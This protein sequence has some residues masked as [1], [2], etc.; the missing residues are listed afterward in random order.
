MAHQSS[1]QIF[2]SILVKQ[3]PDAEKHADGRVDGGMRAVIPRDAQ[4]GLAKG[5]GGLLRHRKRKRTDH[6]RPLDESYKARGF[7]FSQRKPALGRH[8]AFLRS[9]IAARP[10]K[11]LNRPGIGRFAIPGGKWTRGVFKPLGILM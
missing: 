3:V 1:V 11:K 8:T 2:I 7:L 4:K 5:I 10:L 6:A 9:D